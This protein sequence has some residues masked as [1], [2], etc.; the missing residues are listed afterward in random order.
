MRVG[1]QQLREREEMLKQQNRELKRLQQLTA[2]ALEESPALAASRS[3]LRASAIF[4]PEVSGTP[5]GTPASLTRSL[6]GWLHF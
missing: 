2:G 3:R 1:W 6:W 5:W 4:G